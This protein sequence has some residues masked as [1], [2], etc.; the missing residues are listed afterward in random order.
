[1]ILSSQTIRE[2]R[3]IEPFFERTESEGMTFGLG[4][5]GYDVTVAETLQFQPH[6]FRLASTLERFVMPANVIGFV[7]DKSTWARCGLA[8]QNT[9]IEP[10]WRGHLT[11]EITNHRA[12]R[13]LVKRGMPIA[14]IVFQFLDRATEQPYAGKY[15]DQPEGPQPARLGGDAA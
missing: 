13:L 9:V 5:A 3:I 10:G 6:D 7:H 14:Q 2:H 12:E 8:V 1:M 4:P 15:Q 11:L